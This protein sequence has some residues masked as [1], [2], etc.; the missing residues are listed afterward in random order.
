[1]LHR[2]IIL[3]RCGFTPVYALLGRFLPRLRLRA[4]SFL[5]ITVL[6]RPTAAHGPPLLLAYGRLAPT[7]VVQPSRTGSPKRT[8]RP[9]RLTAIR[10]GDN[11]DEIPLR[12]SQRGEPKSLSLVVR[13]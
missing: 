1:M 4:A 2:S 11:L 8:G 3:L 7:V 5:A 13:K 6:V 12:F 9:E 10:V